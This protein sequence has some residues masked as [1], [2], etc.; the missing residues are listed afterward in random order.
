MSA[1]AQLHNG[2]FAYGNDYQK[3]IVQ[4]I[5]SDHKFAE[6]MNEVIKVDYFDL[7]YLKFIVQIIFEYYARYKDFPSH[8][9]ITVISREKFK[10]K[11]DQN[12]LLQISSYLNDIKDRPLNGDTAYVKESSLDFCKKQSLKGTMLEIVDLVD[13]SKYD[14]II[15]KVKKALEAGSEKD[16][17][18]DYF[19]DIDK[20]MVKSSRDTISTGFKFLDAKNVLDGGFGRGELI[21]MMGPSGSGKS[22]LCCIFGAN[23]ILAGKNVIHYTFELSKEKT[24]IR[25]D[26]YITGIPQNM[27]FENREIL[28]EKLS[29]LSRETNLGKLIIKE[30]PTKSATVQTLR[31]HIERVQTIKEFVPDLIIVDYADIMK[32]SKGYDAKRFELESIY[33]ELRATAVEIKVPIITASQTNRSSIKEEVVTLDF[34]AESY[35]KAM[36][37]DV[38][39]TISRLDDDKQKGMA[40]L[41]LAKN[42]SGADGI[43]FPCKFSTH[44]INMEIMEPTGSEIYKCQLDDPEIFKARLREKLESLGGG[45]KQNG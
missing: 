19:E 14:D 5:M 17:G 2:F 35:N 26:S 16:I 32:S 11:K 18:H 6:Q 25:Y 38:I 21:I 8:E 28:R 23:A 13:N 30:W 4:A 36:V 20:R 22:M 40:R 34:I 39:F 44:V 7:A 45:N 37:S 33:E 41:Y 15:G 10:H 3:K 12:I 27:M 31:N 42:R 9:I 24:G 43:V 1:N 29:E